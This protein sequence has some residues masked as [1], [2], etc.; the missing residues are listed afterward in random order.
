MKELAGKAN[1]FCAKFRLEIP[2]GYIGDMTSVS[3]LFMRSFFVGWDNP[4]WGKEFRVKKQGRLILEPKAF[5]DFQEISRRA[6]FHG[7]ILRRMFL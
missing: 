3:Q 1:S 6:D 2:P 5:E 4:F 7:D